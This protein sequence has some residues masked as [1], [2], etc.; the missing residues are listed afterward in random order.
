MDMDPVMLMETALATGA[1]A[2][3]SGTASSAITDSYKGF[4]AKMTKLLAGRHISELK[5]AELDPDIVQEAQKLMQLADPAGSRAGKY[6]VHVDY[7]RGVMVGDY[8][9]QNIMNNNTFTSPT[10]DRETFEPALMQLDD[11]LP[12]TFKTPFAV[13]KEPKPYIP[14]RTP[15]KLLPWEHDAVE[16]RDEDSG[17]D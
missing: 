17:T 10:S 15:K 1:A 14:M 3:V 2:G 16:E 11:S 8:N 7:G 12:G 13:S 5:P 9:V 6:V 4:K